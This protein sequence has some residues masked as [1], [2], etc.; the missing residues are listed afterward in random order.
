MSIK[1]L[2]LK[3]QDGLQKDREAKTGEGGQQEGPA[4]EEDG[5]GDDGG[6]AALQVHPLPEDRHA[7]VDQAAVSKPLRPQVSEEDHPEP[8][9]LQGQVQQ[10]LHAE[11]QGRDSI[12]KII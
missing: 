8:P 5:D 4:Q 9:R 12:E 2:C 10:G 11:E 3:S 6:G 7:E 1:F